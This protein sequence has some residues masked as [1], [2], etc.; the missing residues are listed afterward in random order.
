MPELKA[1]Q[2]SLRHQHHWE[3]IVEHYDWCPSCGAT[4]PAPKRD[5]AD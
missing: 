2:E 4:R 3:L 1:Y 5:D